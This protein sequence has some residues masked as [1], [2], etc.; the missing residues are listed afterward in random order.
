MPTYSNPGDILNNALPG[1]SNLTKSAS[2]IV[3]GLMGGL[4]AADPARRATA[5]FGTGSGMPSSDFVRNRGFD[6][7]GQQA[8]GNKQRGF[9]DFLKLISGYALPA[10]GQQIG[11]SQ[12][13]RT[14]ANQEQQQLADQALKKRQ[15]DQNDPVTTKEQISGPVPGIAGLSGQYAGT[16][17]FK[18]KT[19]YPTTGRTTWAS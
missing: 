18:S 17:S 6:L 5:Y 13:N 9:D 2:S 15:L 14:L 8:E 16:P 12:F 1:F 4:P 19:F 11:E 3:G 7:Y 10:A